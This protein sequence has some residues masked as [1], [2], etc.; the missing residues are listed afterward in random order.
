MAAAGKVC[1][2]KFFEFIILNSV[3]NK[4]YFNLPTNVIP[5]P[6]TMFLSDPA[7]VGGEPKS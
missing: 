1:G 2:L 7:V 3:S 6:K 4:K 5:T